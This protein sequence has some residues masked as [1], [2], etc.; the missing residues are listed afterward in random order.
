M[1][2][3]TSVGRDKI[4]LSSS[5]MTHGPQSRRVRGDLKIDFPRTDDDKAKTE[6]G[7]RA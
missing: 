6:R 7:N 5:E 1:L 2:F 4:W 3:H